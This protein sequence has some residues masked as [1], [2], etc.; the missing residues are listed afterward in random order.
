MR[1]NVWC[2]G[3]LYT[4]D[5]TIRLYFHL[6]DVC[7]HVVWPLG[8]T[9]THLSMHTVTH[10]YTYMHRLYITQ[11]RT[12]RSESIWLIKIWSEVNVLFAVTPS[13]ITHTGMES[14]STPKTTMCV[15]VLYNIWSGRWRSTCYLWS[16]LSKGN[17]SHQEQSFILHETFPEIQNVKVLPGRRLVMHLKMF[18]STFLLFPS[19]LQS[20]SI[21]RNTSPRRK[22]RIYCNTIG[23][24]M[25][26]FMTFLTAKVNIIWLVSQQQICFTAFIHSFSITF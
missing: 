13:S 6:V 14:E 17:D 26:T 18:Y 19:E 11:Q 25:N 24:Y 5:R 23:E 4:D 22:F 21:S 16:T 1:G 12:S 20:F 8:N 10:T 3:L 2:V 9:H 7:R 15:C